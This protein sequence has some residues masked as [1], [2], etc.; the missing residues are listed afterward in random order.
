MS[1]HEASEESMKRLQEQ[2]KEHAE[3]THDAGTSMSDGLPSSGG[4]K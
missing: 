1:G 3:A 4:K 2:T